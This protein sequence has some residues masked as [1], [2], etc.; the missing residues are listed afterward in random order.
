MLEEK[1]VM[2]SEFGGTIYFIAKDVKIQVEFNPEH[3]LSYR[4]IGYE[5]RM[6][7]E[8]DFNDDSEDAGELG[9]GHT[10]TALYEIVPTSVRD[11]DPLKYQPQSV[12]SKPYSDEILTLKL[13]FK[14]PH[15]D[16][17]ELISKIVTVNDITTSMSSELSIASKCQ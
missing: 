13:R 16:Q 14:H 10:A 1:K 8:R 3:V 9:S 4:L 6:L 12:S 17:N 7:D 5:N 11:T 2:V 15:N